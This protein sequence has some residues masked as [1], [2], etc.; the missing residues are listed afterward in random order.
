PVYKP[1]IDA[2]EDVLDY[3]LNDKGCLT[4]F[5]AKGNPI[6]LANFVAKPT[7]EVIRDDG[8][9]VER[10]YRIEGVLHGGKPL[11]PVDVKLSDFLSM[12]WATEN[13]GIEV[14]F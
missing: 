5:D 9:S 2:L 6:E 7:K 13:W 14:S 11:E 4:G 1:Y 10:T 3:T 12:K 8:E